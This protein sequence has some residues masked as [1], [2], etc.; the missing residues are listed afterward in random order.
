MVKLPTNWFWMI[1]C[2]SKCFLGILQNVGESILVHFKRKFPLSFIR[3]I[4]NS[5]PLYKHCEWRV[6]V[7]LLS[8]WKKIEFVC[9]SAEGIPA[10]SFTTITDHYQGGCTCASQL[11]YLDVCCLFQLH[12]INS[13]GFL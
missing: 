2:L 3:S 12:M 10:D 4:C 13:T 5:F 9:S 7:C 6:P 11:V 1:K 8:R